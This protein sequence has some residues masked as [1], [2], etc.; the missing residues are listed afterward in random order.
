MNVDD[1][2]TL[3]LM[4]DAQRPT[5]DTAD[6]WC[7]H[8]LRTGLDLYATALPL[9][10]LRG[11]VTGHDPRRQVALVTLIDAAE[12]GSEFAARA[13]KRL[14]D[15]NTVARRASA[16][17]LVA[18]SFSSSA[19]VTWSPSVNPRPPSAPATSSKRR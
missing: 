6:I 5:I 4:T 19:T 12:T 13:V 18:P 14:R 9:D 16:S 17:A 3:G 8:T 1:L 2:V 15:R 7:Q 11:I 10:T